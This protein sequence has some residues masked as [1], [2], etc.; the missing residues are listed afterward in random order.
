M[1]LS[2]LDLEHPRL[3]EHCEEDDD[4]VV[5]HVCEPIYDISP[6][7]ATA[8]KFG[9]RQGTAVLIITKGCVRTS[10]SNDHKQKDHTKQ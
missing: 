3:L 1:A 7:D 10:T 9:S 4:R 5:T 8:L 6:Q 2:R